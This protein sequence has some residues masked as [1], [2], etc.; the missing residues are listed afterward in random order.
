MKSLD[1]LGNIALFNAGI[2]IGKSPLPAICSRYWKRL[3]RLPDPVLSLAA[4]LPMLPFDWTP[5]T[6][7]LYAR[8]VDVR[9]GLRE[10]EAEY[11]C[12]AS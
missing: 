7:L 11:P 2:S 8:P 6:V 1:N 10:S 5:V 9:R 4:L 12:Q 3:P